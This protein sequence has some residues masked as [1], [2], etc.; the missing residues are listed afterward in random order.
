MCW[1][2]FANSNFCFVKSIF[3]CELVFLFVRVMYENYKIFGKKNSKGWYMSALSW[4]CLRENCLKNISQL[5][6]YLRWELLGSEYEE[7]G[8]NRFHCYQ[9]EVLKDYVQSGQAGQ[10]EVWINTCEIEWSM[11]IEMAWS[12]GAYR[13]TERTSLTW[14]VNMLKAGFL[15]GNGETNKIMHSEIAWA[16]GNRRKTSR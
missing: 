16:E 5:R 4:T 14:E 6:N 1:N 3:S 15:W 13:P 9:S 7:T 2:T 12:S 8:E 11:I 10:S